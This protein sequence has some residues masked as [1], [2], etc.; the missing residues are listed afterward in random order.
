[1]M[2]LW[3]SDNP[4]LGRKARQLTDTFNKKKSEKMVEWLEELV[5]VVQREVLL[6]ASMGRDQLDFSME[7]F[8]YDLTPLMETI[9]G[10]SRYY[11]LSSG[12]KTVLLSELKRVYS[13]KSKYED[14]RVEI[15]SQGTSLLVM[16]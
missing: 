15:N 12:D 3:N 14:L 10:G 5:K 1:M 2:G 11:E 16:W 9:D 13:D 8:I 6:E 4:S 7:K